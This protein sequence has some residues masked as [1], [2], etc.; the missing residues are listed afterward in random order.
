[1]KIE[2]RSLPL[3]EELIKVVGLQ[4]TYPYDDLV[5]VE[6][7]PFLLRFNDENPKSIFIHF[8]QD[9]IEK[10]KKEILIKMEYKAF[11][12]GLELSEESKY[13]M[14]Q[15][16]GSQEFQIEFLDKGL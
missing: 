11:N 13:L 8:N 3:A 15:K 4:M 12:L 2:P 1:M 9:C 14:S 7:N 16:E 10:D 5:F 6:H